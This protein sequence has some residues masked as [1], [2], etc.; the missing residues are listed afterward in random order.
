MIM[1]CVFCSFRTDVDD[2]TRRD[3]FRALEELSA[4]LDGVLAFNSGPNLDFE[5][6]SQGYS[7]GFVIQFKS[8]ADLQNYAVHPEHV[9]L[10]Q[11]LC[12]LCV[13]GADGLIVFDL[14]CAS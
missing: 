7:D 14:S 1:H 4:T 8:S 11:K 9:K 12:T 5:H 13:G 3:L 6:M 10:G 2:T